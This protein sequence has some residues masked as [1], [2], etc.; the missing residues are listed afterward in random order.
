MKQV[1]ILQ[2]AQAIISPVILS[3]TVTVRIKQRLNYTINRIRILKLTI[4]A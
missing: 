4:T 2:T 3:F 1:F